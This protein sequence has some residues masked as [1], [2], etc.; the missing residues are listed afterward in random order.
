MEAHHTLGSPSLTASGADMTITTLTTLHDSSDGDDLVIDCGTCLM[1]RTAACTDCMVTFLLDADDAGTTNRST[2]FVST[3]VVR[4]PSS[5][6]ARRRN[7]VDADAGRS[8]HS[9]VFDLDEQRAMRTLFT[10]GLLPALRYQ[11]GE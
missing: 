3:S 4:H 1:R 9:I 7:G 11:A 8:R 5:S 2:A 6:D 10:A